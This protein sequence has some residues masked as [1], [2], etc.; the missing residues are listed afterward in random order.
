MAGTGHEEAR[1][2]RERIERF[3]RKFRLWVTLPFLL[4]LLFMATGF[5]VAYIPSE[6][7]EPNLLPGDNVV[8]M[9][10]WLAYSFG[11]K[12][13]RGD[14]ILFRL[15]KEQAEQAARYAA[16]SGEEMEGDGVPEVLIKRIV[17][18]PGE[19]VQLVGNDVMINGQKL[20]EEYAIEP[21]TPGDAGPFPYA[22]GEPYRVPPDAYFVL[23]DNRQNSDDSRF[24]G[25]VRRENILGKYIAVLYHGRSGLKRAPARGE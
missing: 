10:S 22:E 7:M 24:W 1:S 3:R 5:R 4:V 13:Q 6:S 9:R 12:P 23:G 19:T 11:R 14:I 16:D 15:T 20:N 21:F 2:R 8:T 18:L 17:G 25:A